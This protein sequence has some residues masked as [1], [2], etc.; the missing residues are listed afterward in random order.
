M[1]F[2]IVADKDSDLPEGLRAHAKQEGDRW[3]VSSLPEGWEVGDTVGLRKFLSEE[4]TMRKTA[5]KA[6]QAYEGID[7]AAAAREALQQ[8]KAG[9]LKGS[10][11]IDEFRKSLE[12]KVAAD[13]A[14]KDAMAHGLTKQLTELMV[15]NAAQKAIAEAG[16]NLKLLLPIVKAAVKAETTPDGRLAVSVVDD[17]GKE[18]VSKAAGATSP[19]SINEYVHTLREQAEYKVAFA[20]SGTGGSGSTSSTAG[21]VR[22]S[23]PGSL[24]AREL[25]DRASMHR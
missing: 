23:V 9:A 19:M 22:A 13:L 12:T 8:L 21:A 20:G 10:K 11:E 15:D 14:K 16:G 7:D 5:E 17:S 6:L 4:R 18:L 3:V 1:V 24:S 2:R 25:F